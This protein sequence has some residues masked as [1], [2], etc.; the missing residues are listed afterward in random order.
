MLQYDTV[1]PASLGLLKKLMINP[2]LRDFFL[3]GG[4]AL[5]LQIGH[6]FSKDIDMFSLNE[7]DAGKVLSELKKEFKISDSSAG[8]NTLNF[9]A[10]IS[11]ESENRIK[12]DLIKYS[13]PLLNPV[14]DIDGIRLLSIE[15]I[16]PMKLSAAAGRGSKKDFYDIFY[17]LRTYTLKQM[18]SFF[19]R[20]F[21]DANMF[22]ILKRLM[23]Y[24]DA[25][26]EPDP[27]TIEQIEWDKVKST[28]TAK[29][30]EYLENMR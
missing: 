10:Q 30:N 23:Y 26:H 11:E 6:R 19:E 7:F 27:Q 20:K 15:D 22:H 5:A 9:Y 25:E 8:R 17:L 21:P 2:E 29:T 14:L 12:V 3:V 4:T 16:I 18:F 24:E 13:Y 28:I 1:D